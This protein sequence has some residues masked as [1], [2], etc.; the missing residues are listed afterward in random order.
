MKSYEVCTEDITPC[1]G[2][3]YSIKE[4]FEVEAESPEAYV[5]ENA[6]WPILEVEHTPEG[7]TRI[8]TGDGHGY[9]VIYIFSE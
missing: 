5:R 1:G 4:I 8:T 7:D 3:K 6:R 9:F 2:R